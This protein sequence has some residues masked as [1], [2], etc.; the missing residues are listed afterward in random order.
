MTSLFQHLRC[1]SEKLIIVLFKPK[2]DLSYLTKCEQ[3]VMTN[4]KQGRKWQ[5]PQPFCENKNPKHHGIDESKSLLHI[6]LE[7]NKPSFTTFR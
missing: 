2:R 5:E 1:D 4:S 7:E 6:K 3:Q